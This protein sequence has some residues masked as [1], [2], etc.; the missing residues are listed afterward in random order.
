V[1]TRTEIGVFVV[2]S[3]YEAGIAFVLASTRHPRDCVRMHPAS[4]KVTI[5][6]FIT[7]DNVAQSER[8][9]VRSTGH[10]RR[11]NSNANEGRVLASS[12]SRSAISPTASKRSGIIVK[13]ANVAPCQDRKTR[14]RTL[15]DLRCAA[16]RR[17][18][19]RCAAWSLFRAIDLSILSIVACSCSSR[20]ATMQRRV[21]QEKVDRSSICIRNQ[22]QLEM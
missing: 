12:P 19:P 6:R 10:P 14:F 1:E 20:C 13:F 15:S 2:Q 5:E 9:I 7:A 16:M 4:R 18:A 11:C 8:P 21:L 17:D 22:A 3:R